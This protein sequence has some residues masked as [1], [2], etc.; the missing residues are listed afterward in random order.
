MF[1]K[2]KKIET[3]KIENTPLGSCEPTSCGSCDVNGCSSSAEPRN[4]SS[5][6]QAEK[7]SAN[8]IKYIIAVGS[9]KGGVGKS[10]VT[11]NLGHALKKQGYSV[12]ILDADIY[13]PS[14][15]AMLGGKK[16]KAMAFD[17]MIKPMDADGI[18]FISMGNLTGDNGPVVW[19]A[20]I[21]V[22]AIKQF[23]NGVHWGELDFLLIDLPPG[24]GDIQITLVQEAQLT[25]AII[26]STPQRVASEVARLGLEMFKQVNIPIM[27]IVENMANFTCPECN[28]ETKLYKSKALR[29]MAKATGSNIIGSVP[30]DGD[31]ME[32]CDEGKSVF[33]LGE[34][35]SSALAFTNI[36]MNVLDYLKMPHEN[37][38]GVKKFLVADGGKIELN[39]AD[40]THSQ[41]N[42]FDL[43]VKCKC[44]LCVDEMTGEPLL[45]KDEIQDDIRI[46][47]ADPVGL[48]GM[49]LRFTDG[50]SSGIY[51]LEELR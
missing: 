27:G 17:N 40:G 38:L 39:W 35:S 2:K 37:L 32:A 43:R 47:G 21:A 25:G 51:K 29:N 44:A 31:L 46:T 30:L 48:Y 4:N 7:S 9:G 14:Q 3:K 28:S 36:A 42:A 24:T 49:S 45:K 5:A 8:N 22:Q 16:E 19:R 12:G 34:K 6:I 15:G 18:K 20:P 41:H 50:H 33:S 13:G 26:V 23:L 10:T 11:M 1:G